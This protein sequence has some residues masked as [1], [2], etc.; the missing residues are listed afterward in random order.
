MT[1]T[2]TFKKV[3][4]QYSKQPQA[5]PKALQALQGISNF[6]FAEIT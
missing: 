4:M 6:R 3:E 1:L 2:L 5:K